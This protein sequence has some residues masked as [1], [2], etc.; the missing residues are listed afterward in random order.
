MDDT[1]LVVLEVDR[2][3]KIVYWTRHTADLS[4]WKRMVN[5]VCQREMGEF[6][7]EEDRE[8]EGTASSHE[9]M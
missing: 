1:K 5:N 9:Y 7:G 6:N 4:Q 3:G 2:K 8:P